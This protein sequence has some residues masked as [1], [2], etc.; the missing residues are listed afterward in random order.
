MAQYR[1]TLPDGTQYKISAP[2]GTSEESI[3]AAA[4]Q[5]AAEARYRGSLSR[6]EE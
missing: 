3:R 5:Y 2:E 4:Q 6:L 1:V